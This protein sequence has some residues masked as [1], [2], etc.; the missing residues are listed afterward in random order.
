MLSVDVADLDEDIRDGLPE[1]VESKLQVKSEREGTVISFDD[2][3]ERTHV[4]APEIKTYLKRF[5]HSKELRK[6]YRLL[7]DNGTIKFVKLRPDQMEEEPEEE[8]KKKG[9]KKGS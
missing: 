7:S 1:F 2:K 3:N 6:K 4:S 8:E 9:K 5:L